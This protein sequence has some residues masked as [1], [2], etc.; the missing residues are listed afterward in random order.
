MYLRLLIRAI[1]FLLGT[2]EIYYDPDFLQK[3]RRADECATNF[4]LLGWSKRSFCI[5]VPHSVSGCDLP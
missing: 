5:R 4:L 3:V 2:Q 1:V